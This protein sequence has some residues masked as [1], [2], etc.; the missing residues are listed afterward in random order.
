MKNSGCF[1]LLLSIFGILFLIMFILAYWKTILSILA[2]IV[3]TLTIIHY[4]I[5]KRKPEKERTEFTGCEEHVPLSATLSSPIDKVL[6]IKSKIIEN[7]QE[8]ALTEKSEI[9]ENGED[10]VSLPVP[11]QS[12][13]DE[14]EELINYAQQRLNKAKELSDIVNTTTNEKTFYLY[15]N[16]IN[17]ILYELT[18]YEGI[19]PFATLP[20]VMLKDI[21]KN[22]SKSIELLQ[23]R[24]RRKNFNVENYAR[25]CNAYLQKQD[26]LENG[27]TAEEENFSNLEFQHIKNFD[28]DVK[29]FDSM[30]GH[31]FEYFCAD[32]LKKNGYSNVEVTQGSGDHGVDVLAE[33]DGISYAI[34][35]KCYSSNIG[36]AAVQQAHTGKTIYKKD[37]AVVLTNRYF[38]S[39]AIEEAEIL[40]VKLWDRDKL[41][42]FI[43]NTK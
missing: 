9:D 8:G 21:A 34:Q 40:G 28:T 27:I 6:E 14:T 5:S 11:E 3:L 19:V 16:Q 37:I 38:T 7:I 39:Q 32:L 1:F 20:S 30:N 17:Q 36:N 41:N 31:D 25:M 29:N 10:I 35:C 42:E 13:E 4:I 18:R 24:V 15:L 43:E 33:K 2:I 22:R 23:E 12:H 26:R